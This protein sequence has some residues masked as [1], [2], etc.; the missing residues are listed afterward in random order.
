MNVKDLFDLKGKISVVTGGGRGIG[1]FIATGL[2][3]AGSDVVIASRKMENLEK[4]VKEL[5]N[6][7][8][9][10]LAVKCDLAKKEDIDNLVKAAMDK[11]GTIDIL[12][13]NAGLTWGA[14]T[15]DY[16]LDKWEKYLTLMSR[17]CGFF[18]SRLP[19]L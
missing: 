2:A 7:G 1:K 4:E 9:R 19:G 10:A 15:L 17:A 13:N 3:E 18:P 11:F 16:P 14:P 5:E 12:V 6:L 8:I